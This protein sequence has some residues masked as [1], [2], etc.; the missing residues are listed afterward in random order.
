MS[1]TIFDQP[2]PGASRVSNSE[3]HAATGV[4]QSSLSSRL[5]AGTML[6][7]P[8]TGT[9]TSLALSRHARLAFLGDAGRRAAPPTNT[10]TK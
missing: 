10:R 4:H 7:A 3:Q 8:R 9:A 6:P 1:Q 2:N 5:V